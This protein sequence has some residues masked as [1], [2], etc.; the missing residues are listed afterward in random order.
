LQAHGNSFANLNRSWPFATQELFMGMDRI[1][2]VVAI[3]DGP[4][5]KK[6]EIALLVGVESIKRLRRASLGN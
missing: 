2:N 5:M 6:K 1:P 4:I 3:V